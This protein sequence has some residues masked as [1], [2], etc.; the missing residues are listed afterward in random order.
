MTREQDLLH[1]MAQVEAASNSLHTTSWVWGGLIADI[2]QGFFL[3]DHHDIDYL[4]RDLIKMQQSLTEAF[5][6]LG[7][8]IQQLVNGDLKLSK[9]QIEVQLGNVTFAG[10]ACWTHNG[11]LGSI[12][13][14]ASWL[15]VESMKFYKFEIHAAE[16][17]LQYAL[18]S[19]PQLL[20][21]D[22][23]PREKDRTALSYLRS[24]LE[25]KK[26]RLDDLKNLIHA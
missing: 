4:T 20:N 7:W 18:L 26:A 9:G 23:A 17:E 21:P 12:F 5:Q 13:F 19:Q 2:Y 15:R 10:E 14:P 11:K 25:A 16:P 24:L 6:E 22:W 3:R 1:A 8:Q